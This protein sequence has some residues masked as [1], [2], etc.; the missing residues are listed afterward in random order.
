MISIGMERPVLLAKCRKKAGVFRKGSSDSSTTTLKK[1]TLG[2]L[3]LQPCPGRTSLFLC[4]PGQGMAV[5]AYSFCLA[6]HFEKKSFFK[7]QQCY[8]V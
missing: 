3:C 7:P 2:L 4:N 1:K 6:H 8:N 5:S